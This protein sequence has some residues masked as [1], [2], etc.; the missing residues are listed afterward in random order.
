[1]LKLC[2]AVW[3]GSIGALFTFPGLRMAR[4]QWDVLRYAD[5][6]GPATVLAHAAFVAPLMLTTLWVSPIARDTLTARTY[7]GMDKPL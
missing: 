1:V 6:V 2:L 3:C 4:M 7:S 5:G